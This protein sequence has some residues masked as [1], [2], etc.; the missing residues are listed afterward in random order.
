MKRISL[1]LTLALV[2][3]LRGYAFADAQVEKVTIKV[4]HSAATEVNLRTEIYNGASTM[5]R[6][7]IKVKLF[8]RAD[9]S[10]AWRYIYTYP[11]VGMVKVG[12]H[13]ALDYFIPAHHLDPAF[14]SSH[15]QVKAVSSLPSG[16]E[17]ESIATHDD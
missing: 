7:P 1:L 5:Q 16:V 14:A 9:S 6:G 12:Q 15:F 3:C 11:A 17:S 8:V 13:V 10:E 4:V 2:F